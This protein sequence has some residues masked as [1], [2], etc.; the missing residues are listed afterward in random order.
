MCVVPKAAE[1]CAKPEVND[2]LIAKPTGDSKCLHLF[3]WL[4]IVGG[5][6]AGCKACKWA[7]SGG[8]FANYQVATL[9][10]S[11]YQKHDEWEQNIT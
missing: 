7:K 4:E 5:N 10:R 1:M 9:K 11:V 6:L 3:T 2:Q 8:R